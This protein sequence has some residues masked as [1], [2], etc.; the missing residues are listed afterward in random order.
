MKNT[1]INAQ[2]ISLQQNQLEITV[3]ENLK[4]IKIIDVFYMLK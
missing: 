1:K 2:Q 4:G 3:P